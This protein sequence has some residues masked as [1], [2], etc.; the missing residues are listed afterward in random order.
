M[1]QGLSAKIILM[2][3]W[4]GTSR[5]SIK[6]SLSAPHTSSHL[7]IPFKDLFASF[8]REEEPWDLRRF[9]LV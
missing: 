7:T 8:E 4:I 2:F 6:N 9:H 3:E 1:A 5:L